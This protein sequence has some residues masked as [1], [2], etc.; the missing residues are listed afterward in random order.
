MQKQKET[1]QQKQYE[2]Q[3][4]LQ[5]SHIHSQT[6]PQGMLLLSLILF[7][8][9]ELEYLCHPPGMSLGHIN[10]RQLDIPSKTTS[11]ILEF[12]TKVRSSQ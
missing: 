2:P 4:Q 8:V 7:Q 10:S 3:Q 11:T 5:G 12:A 6:L 9:P 1:M